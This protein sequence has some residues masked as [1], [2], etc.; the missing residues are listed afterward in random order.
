MTGP[1]KVSV[2][3]NRK[4]A[5]SVFFV[6]ESKVDISIRLCSWSFNPRELSEAIILK[7]S[8]P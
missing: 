2:E 4:N 1:I 6:T 5:N 7:A 3:R 8:P